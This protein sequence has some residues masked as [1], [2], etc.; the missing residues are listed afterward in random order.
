MGGGGE[1]MREYVRV[2]GYERGCKGVRGCERIWEGM[3]GV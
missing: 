1:S 2:E 3:R